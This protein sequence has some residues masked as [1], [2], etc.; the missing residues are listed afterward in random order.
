M[1]EP[2]AISRFPLW[3]G[4]VFL[5]AVIGLSVAGSGAW[6]YWSA[7]SGTGGN[8]LA[9]ASS[10][11]AG[12]TPTAISS[13]TTVKVSWAASTLSS[14]AAVSGYIV[15]R[16]NATT[17]ALQTIGS[18]CSGTV[19]VLTCT[20][21]SVPSGQWT[22]TITPVYSTNWSGAESPK[23]AVAYTDPTAPINLVTLNS[24]TGSA[25]LSGNTVY[26]NGS[27]AGSFTLTN[28]VTDSGSGPGSSSTAALGG[29]STGWTTAPSSV[30]TPT[31]GPFVSST[32]SWASATTSSPTETVTGSDRANNTTATMLTF[33]NDSTA[34]TGSIS[35]IN[36]YQVGR[37]VT[38]TLTG[39]D[40]G[41][42]I[43]SAL[44]QRSSASFINGSCSTF[45]AYA[46]I[47][48]AP[49]SPYIDSTV[50]NATCYSYRYVLTDLVGN[51]STATTSSVA[52]VDY[53]GAVKFETGGIVSQWR[54][55][56]ILL[57]GGTVAVDSAGGN[58]AAYVNGVTQ[59]TNGDLVN[60][61][62][63]SATFDGT[64]DY[65]QATSPT[66]LP[67]G[68]AARSVELWFKTTRATQQTLFTYGTPAGAG[69]FGLILNSG[70]ASVTAWG[71]DAATNPSFTLPAAVNDGMWH[72]IVESFSGT[73]VDVF[74][75]GTALAPQNAARLTVLDSYGFQLGAVVTPGDAKSGF[76]FAG[77]FDE[78]AVYNKA[79]TPTDVT[80]HYQLGHNPNSGNS[81][82]VGGYAVAAGL[83]GTGSAYST[84][85][86][87]VLSG[88]KGTDP[89][90]I[91][92]TGFLAFEATA[93]LTSTGNADGACGTFSAF[94]LIAKDPPTAGSLT[95]PDHQCYV[96]A[97][98][99]PDTLGNYTT[100]STGI[101]KV[102]SSLPPVPTFSFT[103]LTST[104]AVGSILYYNP[105]KATGSFT[106]AAGSNDTLSGI[107]TYA[108]P[109][110][111]T[112]WT[113]TTPTTSS[114]TYSWSLTPTG[115]GAQTVTVTNNASL[116]SSGTFTLTPDSSAPTGGTISYV[117]GT[118]TRS[119]PIT[120]TSG[121]DA[122]S[123]VVS[124]VIL[125]RSEAA[126]GTTCPAFAPAAPYSTLVTNPTSPYS[127][128]T[129]V[130]GNCYQYEIT[131]TD[132]VGNA[133]TFTSTSV[134][135]A[136]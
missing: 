112:N 78:V 76:Y 83:T 33:V 32:F 26:Y 5:A 1:M 108:F 37:F 110:F 51:T 86:T 45:G 47:A 103:N 114:R 17:S 92:A 53:A 22:Y 15:K 69:E 117:N 80:N 11:G 3:R 94:T 66:G 106:V 25:I 121:S 62:N 71:G 40:S 74:I 131:V 23:S 44:L 54:L 115:S 38:V 27:T 59:G 57:T 2:A 50:V 105:A 56:D 82:P 118:A 58:T 55:G 81:G 125:R 120:F 60:D 41:S 61:N 13:G 101:I 88:S 63:T 95:V 102:D 4:I 100:Y 52:W 24:V 89:D 73:A 111:G 72:Y 68:A 75:D 127:D 42:G 85:T 124:T 122:G 113:V 43:A 35:Y 6:A 98:S 34:P 87:L 48:T 91:A 39:S 134:V 109:T 49:T 119:T 19:T 84:S 97:Y 14:G 99:V 30:S 67:I 128:A 28:A 132:G 107:A 8:G 64:N 130:V 70:A 104:W 77:T 9:L 135:R 79:L 136:I 116:S 12:Q 129:L 31:G 18:G 36:G 7:G 123:G 10:V 21:T 126:S 29:T 93:P 133:A 65:L 90:G 16:Y 20:E 96:F 46:T